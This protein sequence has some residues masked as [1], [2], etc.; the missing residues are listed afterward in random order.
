[1]STP[2]NYIENTIK[3]WPTNYELIKNKVNFVIN[4]YGLGAQS[5]KKYKQ[6]VDFELFS[7]NK[8][9]AELSIVEEFQDKLNFDKMSKVSYL[10]ESVIMKYGDRMNW[11]DL[12]RYQRLSEDVLEKY[13]NHLDF[14]MLP[15][16]QKLSEAFISKYRIK[17][18]MDLVMEWQNLSSEFRKKNGYEPKKIDKN[19]IVVLKQIPIESILEPQDRWA[20]YDTKLCGFL[21]PVG[22][23]QVSFMQ[24]GQEDLDETLA[25]LNG[26]S[27]LNPSQLYALDPSEFDNLQNLYLKQ[28]INFACHGVD[29]TT[30][31]AVPKLTKF[32]KPGK[33]INKR[34]RPAK[35]KVIE[36]ES[37]EP[38]IKKAR[39]R[40]KKAVTELTIV[41]VIKRPKGRP[42]KTP[43]L[44]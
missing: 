19:N 43:V 21:D 15:V 30:F 3:I 42:R 24:W 29:R 7:T 36:T 20:F 28:Y 4:Y 23:T 33:S 12:L 27:N 17:F 2:L 26:L 37:S 6:Y 41:D 35:D 44:V 11:K 39:G 8:N 22:R 32:K 10:P 34:G 1:M 38:K 5:I 40:P 9:V 14:N 31:H 13:I 16:F 25:F 18:N